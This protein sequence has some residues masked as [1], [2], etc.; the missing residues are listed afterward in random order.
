MSNT[1]GLAANVRVTDTLP[2]NVTYLSGPTGC[3]QRNI[4][5]LNAILYNGSVPANGQVILTY[6]VT[7][8]TPL[9]NGTV[10]ANNATINDSYTRFDTYAAGDDGHPVGA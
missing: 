5:G 10:I 7:I 4:A 1:G 9:D 8:D 6:R 3:G 2:A